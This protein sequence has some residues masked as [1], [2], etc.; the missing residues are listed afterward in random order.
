MYVLCEQQQEIQ[1]IGILLPSRTE[2][3]MGTGEMARELGLF[4]R[5]EDQGSIRSPQMAVCK[6][7]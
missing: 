6:C 4:A 7:L 5:P 3:V 2:P 1:A